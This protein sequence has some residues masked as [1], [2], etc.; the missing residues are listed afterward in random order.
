MNVDALPPT[1]SS[2]EE[3]IG[4]RVAM[5]GSPFPPLLQCPWETHCVGAQASYD[6][7]PAAELSA[8]PSTT[9]GQLML[10]AA[11]KLELRPT[12]ADERPKGWRQSP[13]TVKEVVSLVDFY[14]PGDAYGVR[15]KPFSGRVP[16]VDE[17]NRL[18]RVAWRDARLADAVRAADEGFFPGDPRRP[19]LV[20]HPS[21]GGD[22][23]LSSWETV[24]VSIRAAWEMA[25]ALA[26]LGGSWAALAGIKQALQRTLTAISEQANQ[27]ADRGL[28]PYDVRDLL[29]TRTVW[30]AKEV[31]VLFDCQE[32]HAE[33][34]LLAMGWRWDQSR[35]LWEIGGP[36]TTR[37]IDVVMEDVP[38]PQNQSRAYIRKLVSAIR[39]ALW[40]IVYRKLK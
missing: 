11:K 9:L 2:A 6:E 39:A 7:R 23:W 37:L 12:P 27:W 17:R 40:L 24:E 28:D 15:R 3:R 29:D 25:Q 14:R 30:T 20:P 34:L 33:G 19:Y 31:A 38:L 21:A 22:A 35:Q 1:E 10:M 5:L 8:A 16:V 18:S 26:V 32:A 4:V 13:V 36:L